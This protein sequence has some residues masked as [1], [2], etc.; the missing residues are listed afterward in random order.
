MVAF[1]LLQVL[2]GFVFVLVLGFELG[3]TL[4]LSYIPRAFKF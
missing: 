1:C 3:G 4:P 2:L